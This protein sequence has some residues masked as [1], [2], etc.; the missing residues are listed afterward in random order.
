MAREIRLTLRQWSFEAR[1][2]KPILLLLAG[3]ALFLGA[4]N[5]AKLNYPV[6]PKG[7][8]VDDY[9]GVKV[10][11]PYRGLENADA[12]STEKWVAQENELT[13]A[14]LAKLPGREAIKKQLTSLWN[15]EKFGGFEKAGNHYFYLRN[16]GL[17][18]QSVLYVMDSLTGP[19]R[20]L[21]D[22]N[23]YRKDG[24]TALAGA[25]PSWNG[26]L[27]GYAIA[28]AGSD[29]EEWRV[30]DVA[31]GKDAPDLIQW[32]KGSGIS[33]AADD[34]GF[35]YGRYAEPPP[36]KLLTVAALDE[37]V[38]FHKLGDPQSADKLIYERPDHPNWTIEPQVTEG[39]RYLLFEMENGVPGTNMLAYQDLRAASPHTVMLI[40]SADHA[41]API[42]VIGSTLYLQTNDGAPRSRVIA[43]DIEHPERARW[44]EIVPERAET[45]DGAQIADGKLLLSYMKDA[46]SAARLVTLD[47]KPV[48]EIAMPGIGTAAWSGAR[49][50]DKEIFYRFEGFT[51][52]PTIYRLDLDTAKSTVIRQSK[53][54][55]DL[56]AYETRQVFYSSKDGTRVPMFLSYKKGL[57]L[58]AQNPTLL[59]AYGGFDIPM[60]PDFRPAIV[61]WMQMGGVY[62]VANLRGGSEYGEAWHQ[63]GMRAKKQNVFDDFIA[64]GEWLIANKY[65]STPKLAVFGGS[66]GGLL[67][68]AV[69]NQRP[70]LFGAAMPAVGVMDMLRFQKFGFGT[71]WVGE[72]GSAD[73]PEDFK[74]LR[75][76]SP[77]HNIR[78]GA[79]YP[80]TLITT[81]DHDDRVMPGHSLK[82]AATLQQ[83][84]EGP[85][86]ILI[87]IE[88]RAGHGAGKPTTKQ[89]D[90][91]ADRFVFLKSALKMGS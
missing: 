11:D 65:T 67:I 26:K 1:F 25:S 20:E 89:I 62:A 22:P 66:N 76:Y 4:D 90:E 17:Q 24:T 40:P 85:S 64:A 72:Y 41:Y 78:K 2:M 12:P 39:G 91:W 32:T 36:E 7:N 59:Y 81:S 9:H 43:M 56:S 52:A 45:L 5:A 33:W 44:K 27:Y 71:Q 70:D 14:Y 3:V 19:A 73:N 88:T 54:P 48:A 87:R 29:W 35:Y 58:D 68:G 8:Q 42:D 28:Q 49:L 86:P 53:V 34:R 15:Y 55:V 47:G 79:E 13:F 37:K 6:A 60:T 21:L 23:T 80:P 16:S 84:Q 83:A 18:N 75:A 51:I 38:Y 30:R 46:H 31:T 82:Y 61:E 77:L 57:K 50:E 63:A 10:A 74:V 69:V